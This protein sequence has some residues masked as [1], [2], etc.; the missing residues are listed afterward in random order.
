[1]TINDKLRILNEQLLKITKEFKTE[2]KCIIHKILIED[3]VVTFEIWSVNE[4]IKIDSFT[5]VN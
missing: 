3:N 2:H 5:F 4:N 1:M